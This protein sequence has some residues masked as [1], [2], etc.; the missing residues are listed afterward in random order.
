MSLGCHRGT[1]LLLLLSQLEWCSIG[2]N[3]S[4]VSNMSENGQVLVFVPKNK[5]TRVPFVNHQFPAMFN[6]ILMGNPA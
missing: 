2:E 3:I 5:R 4:A 1:L 6:I